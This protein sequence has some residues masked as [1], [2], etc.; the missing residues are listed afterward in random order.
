MPAGRDTV[1][2]DVRVRLVELDGDDV[3]LRITPAA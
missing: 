2:G 3:T 1:V